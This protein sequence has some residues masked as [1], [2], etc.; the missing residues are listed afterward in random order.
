MI[1]I[2]EKPKNWEYENLKFLFEVR[3]RPVYKIF[4]LVTEGFYTGMIGFADKKSI[5]KDNFV[6]RA[7]NF[8]NKDLTNLYRR[9][10]YKLDALLLNSYS[11]SGNNL[12]FVFCKGRYKG[13]RGSITP[14]S[15]Q[16]INVSLGWNS[17]TKESRKNWIE[18]YCR[19]NNLTILRYPKDFLLS[20]SFSVQKNG[21]TWNTTVCNLQQRYSD[22]LWYQGFS[23]GELRIK[24]FLENENIK[25][26]HQKR[27]YHE[28]SSYQIF[29]FLLPD[30][31]LA[32]EYNGEQH[33]KETSFFSRNL[34]EQ[35]QSDK[36]KE[37]YCKKNN[38]ELLVI[39]YWE[40]NKIEKIL[41]GVVSNGLYSQY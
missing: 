11:G 8:F 7:Q 28:D 41:K 18:N 10:F 2:K 33:Y 40:Y 34:T 14:E 6:P 29:D 24:N 25:F 39:P 19:K 17:L 27:F 9:K 30:F 20:Q 37:L 23:K 35:K 12:Y 13:L 4:F 5:Y 38:I 3:K 15:F 21:I 26:I 16:R 1:I 31:N 22:F 36:K 32:I